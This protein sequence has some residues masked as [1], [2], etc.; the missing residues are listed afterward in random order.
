M[1]RTLRLVVASGNAHKTDEIR[2]ILGDSVTSVEDLSGYPAIKEIKETGVTFEENAVIKALEVGRV[3]G[4]KAWVLS[5]DSGLEVDALGGKPGVY[6][7]RYAGEAA[8]DA[9]NRARLLEKMA[10][11]DGEENSRSA[12]FRCAMVLARGR[13]KIAVFEGA[14]E[15]AIARTEKGEQGFG[16]DSLFIPEGYS[17]TFGQL[18]PEVKNSMSHRGRALEKFK[19]WLA[20]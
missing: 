9:D 7:A 20:R 11:I 10:G 1:P 2:R 12:R 17:E 3:L 14:L 5:D 19:L 15:G 6:S 18:P 13:E 4:D 8:S 16:Y